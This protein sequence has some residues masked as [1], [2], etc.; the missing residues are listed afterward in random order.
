MT[1]VPLRTA[2][3]LLGTLRGHGTLLLL[4]SVGLFLS[5]G[6]IPKGLERGLLD[7][8]LGRT[9]EATAVLE[10]KY[11]DGDRSAA[12]T[13]ALARARVRTG[14]VSGAVSLLE[15]LLEVRP[16]DPALLSTLAHHYRDMQRPV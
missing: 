15:K 2:T 13:A 4:A 11:R 12:T 8:E 5:I 14:D 6:A 16:R 9:E 1:G 3:A 10:A 7:L